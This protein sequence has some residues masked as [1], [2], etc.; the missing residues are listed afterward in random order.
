MDIRESYNSAARAYADHLAR[1]LEQK[2]LD[3]A[4]LVRFAEELRGSGVVLDLG[5][6]PGHVAAFLAQHGVSVIG[7]DVSEEMVACAAERNPQL[8]FRVG[9]MRDLDVPEG[10]I[11]GVVS[12]YSIVHFVPAEL[13]GLFLE[14]RRVI[15][16][17]GLLLLG[18]HIGEDVVHA[19]ELFGAPVSLDFRF[20]D[21][22]SVIDALRSAGFA[23]IE[24]SEREP[25]AGAEYQSRRCYLLARAV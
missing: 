21:P 2:P 3:R 14:F 8:K 11:G 1:E 15:R 19:D 20:H 4:L 5:C 17:G 25:Y 12:F 9:D 18:F 7:V 13:P 6:G 22:A 16:Q 24:R 10:S 23:T